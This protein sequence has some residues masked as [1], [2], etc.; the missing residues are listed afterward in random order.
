MT[1][2]P[3][4]LVQRY[5]HYNS[6]T[7]QPSM[8]WMGYPQIPSILH[9]SRES[10]AAGLRV[11]RLF[12]TYDASHAARMGGFPD[13]ENHQVYFNSSLDTLMA[14]GLDID[15]ELEELSD[16]LEYIDKKFAAEVRSLAFLGT[17]WRHSAK[18]GTIE[19][20]GGYFYPFATLEKLIVVPEYDVTAIRG[21]I[22]PN[23]TLVSNADMNSQIGFSDVDSDIDLDDW[24]W[25]AEEHFCEGVDRGLAFLKEGRRLGNLKWSKKLEIDVA[26]VV[27]E[28]D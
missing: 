4:V 16:E 15:G 14:C 21:V 11:Y 2:T 27:D 19:M 18:E 23:F 17:K 26:N 20:F 7:I 25:N 9:V 12:E 3:R 6:E 5:Q 10:R 22:S 13:K 1:V 24:K 28:L 8:N